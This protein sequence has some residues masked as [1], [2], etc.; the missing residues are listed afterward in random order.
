MTTGDQGVAD[1]D[2][3]VQ[4]FGRDDDVIT[5]AGYRIGPAEIEDCLTAPSG[6]SARRGGR[7]ARPAAHRDRQGV[8]GAEA[9]LSKPRRRSPSEIRGFVRERLS[10]HEYPREVEFVETMPLTT[11]GKV[12][13]RIFRE[14]A[15]RDTEGRS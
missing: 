12:I 14:R 4:F 7:Q 5:S 11:T 6:G 15:R 2:G 1:S 9:G 10:A 13:R 3:Y 8:R